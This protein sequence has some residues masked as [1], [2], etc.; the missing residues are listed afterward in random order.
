MNWKSRV[1]KGIPILYNLPPQKIYSYLLGYCTELED[2]LNLVQKQLDEVNR[3]LAN[4]TS[5]N[6]GQKSKL[7]LEIETQF[8]KSID[9]LLLEDCKGKSIREIADELGVSKS[10]AANWLKELKHA[11][12]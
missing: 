12:Q 1:D 10:T 9:K 11:K 3:T 4:I 7:M 6:A 5:A 8:G 2:K